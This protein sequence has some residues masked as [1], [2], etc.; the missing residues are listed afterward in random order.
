MLV[1]I[2][3][4]AQALSFE[5][6]ESYSYLTLLLPTGKQ[7]QATVADDV[8]AELTSVF[9]GSGSP[10]AQAAT[11]RVQAGLSDE[12]PPRPAPKQARPEGDE[13]FAQMGRPQ[14]EEPQ[15]KSFS[16]VDFSDGSG[17]DV[18]AFGGDFQGEDTA[19]LQAIEQQMAAAESKLAG[20]VGDIST[21]NQADLRKVIASLNQTVPAQPVPNILTAPK[22]SAPSR[23]VE[24]DSFGNPI[25]RGQGLVDPRSLMGGNT[26]GEEDAGQV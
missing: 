26:E 12:P 10:A 6:G 25:I 8:I 1:Q 20:A 17:E 16:P 3:G 4:I 9:M 19:Q 18:V 7:V 22:Q 23:H 15:P 5:T 13:Y 11:A 21:T 24:A 14:S 2:V